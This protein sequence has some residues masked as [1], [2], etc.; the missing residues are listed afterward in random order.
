MSKEVSNFDPMPTFKDAMIFGVVDLTLGAGLKEQKATIT[1]L[2]ALFVPAG[3]DK[4]VQLNSS[5]VFGASD[6]FTFDNATI[7]VLDIN[8][9]ADD[10]VITLSEAGV[11]EFYIAHDQGNSR[12]SIGTGGAV[13]S[14]VILDYDIGD[15][16]WDFHELDIKMKRIFL[17]NSGTIR[18]SLATAPT[19]ISL[20]G[21]A[22]IGVAID[23][24]GSRA[25]T[26]GDDQVAT[27]SSYVV[28]FITDADGTVEGSLWYDASE[29]KLKF[30]TG[31]GVETIT[32][33]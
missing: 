15:S 13:S 14:N 17:E 33:A 31:A 23:A 9:A 29:D 27:F 16:T 2:K 11:P 5:G 24:G 3:N 30:K 32:S 22:G 10:S 6:D 21:N 18:G 8:S 28:L 19:Q 1:Q 12:L 7:S 4:A 26:F 20:T 25:V